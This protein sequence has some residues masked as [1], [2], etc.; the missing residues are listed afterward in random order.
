MSNPAPVF[1]HSLYRYSWSFTGSSFLLLIRSVIADLTNRFLSVTPQGSVR[2]VF[3]MF[4]VIFGNFINATCNTT[5]GL[6][7]LKIKN[8]T[9][10]SF[11]SK[12]VII[13]EELQS[14]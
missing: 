11:K 4:S 7:L 14:V 3:R 6:D 9:G 5:I 10:K 2:A 13:E 8:K 12:K 1:A